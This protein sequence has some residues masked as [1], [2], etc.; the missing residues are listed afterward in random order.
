LAA[1]Q[2][3]GLRLTA[4][5]ITIWLHYCIKV[6]TEIFRLYRCMI[7]S[8]GDRQ[9]KSLTFSFEHFYKDGISFEF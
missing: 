1:F 7:W 2:S 5:K 9:T 8:D 4:L 6:K 3:D